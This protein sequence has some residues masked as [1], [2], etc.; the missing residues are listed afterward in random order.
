MLYSV[1]IGTSHALLC[2]ETNWSTLAERRKLNKFRHFI[3]IETPSARS[4]T[5]KYW[6][7]LAQL[8]KMQIVFYLPK[9][10]TKTIKISF[11]PSA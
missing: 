10:R 7:Y 9:L 11:M 8:L 4:T 2:K 5:Y 6:H 1:K 3:N